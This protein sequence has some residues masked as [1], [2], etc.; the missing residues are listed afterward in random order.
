VRIIKNKI[1]I[2]SLINLIALF[3]SAQNT[4][5]SITQSSVL[6]LAFDNVILDR[7][8]PIVLIHNPKSHSYKSEWIKILGYRFIPQPKLQSPGIIAVNSDIITEEVKVV[9]EKL[10]PGDVIYFL[11]YAKINQILYEI[12]FGYKIGGEIKNKYIVFKPGSYVNL[13]IIKE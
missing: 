9:F 11:V 12:E 5:Q 6:F 10:K 2:L 8:I 1:F 7:N 13:E 4:K 3:I